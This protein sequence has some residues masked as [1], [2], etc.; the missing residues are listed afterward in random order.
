LQIKHYT[1]DLA[2]YWRNSER[3]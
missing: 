2:D 3:S 1:K